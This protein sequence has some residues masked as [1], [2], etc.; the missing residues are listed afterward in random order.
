MQSED[1]EK[2]KRENRKLRIDIQLLTREIDLAD[3]GQSTAQAVI[4]DQI[5]SISVLW[6]RLATFNCNAHMVT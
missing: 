4:Y 6:C 2:L 1:V 5:L 3:N